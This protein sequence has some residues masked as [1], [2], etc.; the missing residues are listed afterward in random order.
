V[1]DAIKDERTWS[2][3]R[4][5]ADKWGP[6]LFDDEWPQSAAETMLDDVGDDLR[7]T[8]RKVSGEEIETNARS[9]ELLDIEGAFEK[10]EPSAALARC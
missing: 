8:W 10:F 5:A 3:K 6:S 1:I 4:A 2:L 9:I 7:S